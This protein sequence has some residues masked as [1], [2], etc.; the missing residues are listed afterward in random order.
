MKLTI[1]QLRQSGYK[2]RVYHHRHKIPVQRI[3]GIVYDISPK[4]GFTTIEITTPD[5]QS[6]VLGKSI[7]SLGDNFNRRL[8]NE[9]ALGRALQQII[10]T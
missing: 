8:G 3:G 10:N 5:K 2:V 9:I 7:C 4:G 6:T 1:K